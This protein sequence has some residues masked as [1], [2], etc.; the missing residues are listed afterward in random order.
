MTKKLN[1]AQLL[2]VAINSIK[3]AEVSKNTLKAKSDE[4]SKLTEQVDSNIE[5]ACTD[6]YA[7]SLAGVTGADMARGAGLSEM[8]VSR[9][10]AGGHVNYV[11]KNKIAGGKVVSDIGNGYLTV[12]KA[13]SVKSA[14][15]YN[16]TVSD[17]KKAKSGKAGK[18]KA[19]ADTLAPLDQVCAHVDGIISLVKSG[20]VTLEEVTDIW[21]SGLAILEYAEE[22]AEV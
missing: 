14:K 21:A 16:K 2:E 22:M 7:A 4:L 6:A 18:V 13:K 9:Y 10:I 1:K 11:T 17:G 19:K 20:K 3:S 12:N 8:T 15:E 5:V